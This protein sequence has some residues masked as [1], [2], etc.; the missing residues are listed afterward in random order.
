MSGGQ[1][2]FEAAG[3][4]HRI[5]HEDDLPEPKEVLPRVIEHVAL[6]WRSARRRLPGG[7]ARRP[8]STGA[9]RRGGRLPRPY[10]QD[11]RG[12]ARHLPRPE[13]ATRRRG[14][15]QVVPC[16]DCS[17]GPSSRARRTCSSTASRGRA[18]WTSSTAVPTSARGAHR[19]HRRRAQ[20]RAGKPKVDLVDPG[21]GTL[22]G[23]PA[24][25]PSSAI[26]SPAVPS[27]TSPGDPPV[28][29]GHRQA[30]G[31]GRPR[32]PDRTPGQVSSQPSRLTTRPRVTTRRAWG[33]TRTGP[34]ERAPRR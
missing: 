10:R 33:G 31:Q 6:R 2:V 8:G 13:Q 26:S 1:A 20:R 5:T 7:E 3:V 16:E 23:G 14:G 12:L 4:G 25:R 21:H 24:H 9:G 19:A 27:R 15:R 17:D 30:P 22:H 18:A 29:R 34:G 28:R 32:E 11:R